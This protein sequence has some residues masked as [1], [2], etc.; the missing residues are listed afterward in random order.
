MHRRL[1]TLTA[2]WPSRRF[3]RAGG[4]IRVL[5]Q[6]MRAEGFDVR[7]VAPGAR[8]GV[9]GAVGFP[10]PV[11]RLKAAAPSRV[12]QLLYV[13]SAAGACVREGRARP[14]DA[15]LVHW[16]LPSGPAALWAARRLGIPLYAWAHGS[17][18]EVYAARGGFLRGAARAVV[19]GASGVF[20][21]SG[22]LCRK[23]AALGAAAV[24]HLPVG[25]ASVF[26]N[27]PPA[28]R[29]DG[30]FTILFCGDFIPAKGVRELIAARRL[31]GSGRLA[32]WVCAGAGPLGPA[33]ARAGFEVR[34]NLDAAGVAALMDAS[35][36][37]VLPSISE[38]TPLVVQEALCR[39]LPVIASAVGGVGELV[40]SGREGLLLAPPVGGRALAQSIAELYDAPELR[41]A[42]AGRAGARGA[43]VRAARETAASFRRTLAA[44]ESVR[45]G[46]PSTP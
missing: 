32:R 2:A 12:L 38:G 25:V 1:L 27:M 37:L 9:E 42:L 10:A 5:T 44:W 30:P 8:G 39:G 13:M 19:R 41:A 20:A 11:V 45:G 17:D 35:H 40:R 31:L 24:A 43:E 21:A 34:V 6:G 26:K 16:V 4:F 15:L 3:P 28:P 14:A 22:S 7:V 18:L 29:P 36:V 23:A 46:P 33:L